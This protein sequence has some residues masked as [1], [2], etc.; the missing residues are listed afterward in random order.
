MIVFE[1]KT[2]GWKNKKPIKLNLMGFR[3]KEVFFML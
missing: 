2:D 3:S 1:F